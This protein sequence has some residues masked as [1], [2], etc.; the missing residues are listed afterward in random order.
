MPTTSSCAS[1][2]RRTRGRCFFALKERLSQFGLALHED[3]TRLI[4]F[5]R[6]AALTRQR[7]GERRPETFAFMGFIHYR[8]KTGDG[9]FIV[10]HKTEG[11]RLTRKLKAVREEAWR[12][13][14]APL[15]IQHDWYSAVLRDQWLLR[16]T[17]QLPCAQWFL[18]RSPSRCLPC[19]SQKSR[20]MAWHEFDTLTSRFRLP[21]PRI[22]RSWAQARM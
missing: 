13:M 4:E 16:Q 7:R 14:H 1:R 15:A 10:K 21:L 8:G 3:K 2:R 9:R 20:R 19:R 22:T 17:A 11:K 12:F 18:P 5:G 6:F